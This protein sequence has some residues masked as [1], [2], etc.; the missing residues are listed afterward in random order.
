MFYMIMEMDWMGL[1]EI[2]ISRSLFKQAQVLNKCDG[3]RR[4]KTANNQ[5]LEMDRQ[6]E[7]SKSESVKMQ[8][9]KDKPAS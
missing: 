1:T 9:M 7:R 6:V 8:T 2:I 3:R 5:V 4:Q